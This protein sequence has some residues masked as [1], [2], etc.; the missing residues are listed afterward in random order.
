MHRLHFPSFIGS[1]QCFLVLFSTFCCLT[2]LL[3]N[4][5]P[6]SYYPRVFD[7]GFVPYEVPCGYQ[8]NLWTSVAPGDLWHQNLSG[9]FSQEVWECNDYSG[10]SSSFTQYGRAVQVAFHTF[11]ETNNPFFMMST[12]TSPWA[13]EHLRVTF[14]DAPDSHGI[15]N[16]YVT[17]QNV[18]D[19]ARGS[20]VK[21]FFFKIHHDGTS[22]IT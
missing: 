4:V 14:H 8:G 13:T 17:W 19:P 7:P 16:S 21:S 2:Q 3:T 9:M 11:K 18:Q 15:I 22:N 6:M 1:T 5:V 20:A 12:R 10:A